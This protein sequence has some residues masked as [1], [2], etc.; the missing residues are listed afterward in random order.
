MKKEFLDAETGFRSVLEMAERHPELKEVED[1]AWQHLGKLKF[2]EGDMKA[3]TDCLNRA[4]E[5][6]KK[7]GIKELIDSTEFALNIIRSKNSLLKKY[8]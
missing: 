7:K 5:L 4:L 3:A 6:R 8:K 1:F 2:D